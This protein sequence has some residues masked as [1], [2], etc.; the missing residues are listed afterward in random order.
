MYRCKNFLPSVNNTLLISANEEG[1]F[2]RTLI[3]FM[4]IIGIPIPNC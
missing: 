2:A 3:V 1:A 4:K